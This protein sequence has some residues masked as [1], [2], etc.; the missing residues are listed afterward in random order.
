MYT[1]SDWKPFD[2]MQGECIHCGFHY[3]TEVVQLDLETVNR[4][5]A[6]YNELDEP[7]KPLEPLTQRDLDEY[8]RAM[9]TI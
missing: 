9:E 6:E 2:T 5:R 1:Y 3:Y 8:A 4:L 7:E